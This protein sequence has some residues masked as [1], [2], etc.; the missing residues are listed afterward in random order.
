MGWDHGVERVMPSVRQADRQAGSEPE[1]PSHSQVHPGSHEQ[2][3]EGSF[4]RARGAAQGCPFAPMQRS[5]LG[6]VPIITRRLQIPRPTDDETTFGQRQFRGYAMQCSLSVLL[7]RLSGRGKRE[8]ASWW[9][10][11]RRQSSRC[12]LLQI[13]AAWLR[14]VVL[15]V[16]G[17]GQ[18]PNTQRER[19]ELRATRGGTRIICPVKCEEPEGDGT[20]T[21]GWGQS[22]RFQESDVQEETR[23]MRELQ[24]KVCLGGEVG[25]FSGVHLRRYISDT[26]FA[27]RLSGPEV[28]QTAP[29]HLLWRA[30]RGP[31]PNGQQRVNV[32][33]DRE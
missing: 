25:G 6:F 10:N 14:P 23:R 31:P 9:W 24:V 15:D 16:L 27:N 20:R 30:P 8:I 29:R 7:C 33:L 18:A 1:E 32:V 4:E 28:R 3:C 22:L 2:S 19:C 12:E 5:R 21:G 17:K 26:P 13:L 11:N